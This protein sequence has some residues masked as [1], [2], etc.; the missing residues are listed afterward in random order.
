[1][2]QKENKNRKGSSLV[3]VIIAVAF[4]GILSTIILRV[5]LINVE[6]KG[7]DRT[8]KRNFY[9]AEAL[10]DKLNVTIEN[11]S[12]EAMKKAYIELLE[13]YTTKDA[14]DT[15]S[16]IDSTNQNEIQNKLAKK[17]LNA[18]ID[19][20]SPGQAMS[21]TYELADGV[22][23]SPEVLKKRMA[24]IVFDDT[25]TN[26]SD[27]IDMKDDD[28]NA[29]LQLHYGDPKDYDAERY[30]L[31]K[32][33][34]IKYLDNKVDK[35]SANS[36]WITTD[37]K[38]EV[39][40]LD[41]ESKNIY[42][43]FTK[44]A[45]IGNEKVDALV[46]VKD[47]SVIGNLYAGDQGLNVTGG[48][49]TLSIGGSSSRVIARGNISIQQTG[50]LTLG[51]EQ[52]PVEVWTENYAT[53]PMKDGKESPAKLTVYGDS[54]VHD[55]LSLDG[56]YSDV[57]FLSGN[58]FGYS[59][60]K[61]NSEDTALNV[62]S[63]Y[64]SA[65]VINGKHSSLVMD[66]INSKNGKSGSIILGG[67]AFI[68]RNR[69]TGTTVG[70]KEGTT[71]RKD[72]P[73]G[74]SISV[75][76]NQNFYLVSDNELTEGFS[77]P[78]TISK[79]NDL[80]KAGKQPLA[81]HAKKSLRS[82]LE[83]KDPIT[84]YVYDLS[85]TSTNAAMVYFYYNFKSQDAADRY[86]RERCDKEDMSKKMVS[87]EYLKFPSGL[88]IKLSKNLAL[89]T[90]GNALTNLTEKSKTVQT[91]EG[92][93]DSDNELYYKKEGIRRA[94]KYK[95]YQLTLTDGDYSKYISESADG[96]NGFNLTD[97]KESPI[98]DALMTKEEDGTY[99]FVKEA[100]ENPSLY[101]FE[102]YDGSRLCKAVPVEINKDT[103]K[104]VYA[105]FIAETNEEA[106]KNGTESPISLYDLL[107]NKLHINTNEAT[108]MI[109]S[110]CNVVVNCNIN[111]LVISKHTV[112]FDGTS[113][114]VSA[115]SALLQEMFS[116]QKEKE[117]GSDLA[118]RFLKYFKV[119]A[120]MTY[121]E[122]NV[123]VTKDYLN[124][125]SYIKYVNWKK[126]NE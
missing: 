86:F 30:L 109:V 54:Y 91:Q 111:G 59:F 71:G 44:Y 57:R 62:N 52:S 39:P 47:A 106:L 75:K 34:R 15:S 29:F 12:Q 72:I 125:S 80:L 43:E 92:K 85:G 78:M 46:G 41:F 51:S 97:K 102:S 87:S 83:Q 119:F 21:A 105:V 74:E 100:R 123:D 45:I 6:T 49:N 9:S 64:S 19:I 55:D 115:S 81:E 118:Q 17:Y 61:D 20:L 28:K 66:N 14:G 31:L 77:N 114:K 11:I 2:E 42:P 3:F 116:K 35:N 117:G 1:M 94:A 50:G 82:Y 33:V 22:T 120:D 70:V 122:K 90:V 88:D 104:T 112:S 103:K 10:T 8:I 24:S 68:S 84:D 69:D 67:R 58:Y 38:I 107:I 89:L 27:C 108:I 124:F 93:I 96:E 101:G 40:K 37:V 23:Y 73:I 25:K 18:L 113:L 121:G 36:T 16:I 60:N 79:Y 7:T 99:T 48:D 76:S 56:P 53:T 126:N 13:N 63:Q 32:N 110:N 26:Y 5:T 4:V 95:S 98:F 65:I